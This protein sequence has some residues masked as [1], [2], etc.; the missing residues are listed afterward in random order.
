MAIK[1]KEERKLRLNQ[2]AAR[3][4]GIIQGLAE[5]ARGGADVISPQEFRDIESQVDDAAG[6]RSRQP[7]DFPQ[8]GLRRPGQPDL[9]QIRKDKQV[10]THG[11]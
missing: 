8:G 1:K 5:R 11:T 9:A 2:V 4:A 7:E 3:E 10:R 6:L